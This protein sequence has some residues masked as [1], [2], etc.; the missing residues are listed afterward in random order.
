MAWQLLLVALSWV[1]IALKH[2]FWKAFLPSSVA[3]NADGASVFEGQLWDFRTVF[4]WA[5]AAV[6][7]GRAFQPQV[8]SS[9]ALLSPLPSSASGFVTRIRVFLIKDRDIFFFYPFLCN[10][11]GKK[12]IEE[13]SPEMQPAPPRFPTC[14]LG[15]LLPLRINSSVSIRNCSFPLAPGTCRAPSCPCFIPWDCQS[16]C[17]FSRVSCSSW[18][19]WHLGFGNI[20]GFYRTICRKKWLCRTCLM[21]TFCSKVGR[22]WSLLMSLQQ[23]GTHLQEVETHTNFLFAFPLWCL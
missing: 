18:G 14:L 16:L 9:E 11:N 2:A 22:A 21:L 7:P 1:C 17:G 20:H 15:F 10:T 12:L 3:L 8:N 19:G 13:H 6:Q 5:A 23:P 4:L